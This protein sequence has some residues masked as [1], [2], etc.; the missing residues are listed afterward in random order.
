IATDA[1]KS[2]PARRI[3]FVQRRQCLRITCRNRALKRQ[4]DDYDRLSLLEV[5]K[6]NRLAR[7]VPQ[8]EV[9]DSLAQPRARGII[10]GDCAIER[11]GEHDNQSDRKPDESHH[12]P[13]VA[14][15]GGPVSHY[16]MKPQKVSDV[17]VSRWE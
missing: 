17:S 1:E 13:Q 4:E 12:S 11:C 10:L 14:G 8:S 7:Q 9:V 15:G 6:G 2:H 5:A 3:F 16:S